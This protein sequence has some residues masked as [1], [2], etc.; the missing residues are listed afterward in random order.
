MESP[1]PLSGPSDYYGLN[2]KCPSQPHALTVYSLQYYFAGWL[3]LACCNRIPEPR[4][5]INK[6]LALQFWKLTVQD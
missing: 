4:Y 5:F 3:A 2:V 1:K 6:E